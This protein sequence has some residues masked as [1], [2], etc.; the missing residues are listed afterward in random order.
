MTDQQMAA[1][2][3]GRR[4]FI[5]QLLM[6]LGVWSLVASLVSSVYANFRFFF[7][8]VLYEPPFRFRAGYPHEYDAGSISDRWHREHRVWMVRDGDTLYAMLA[9]CTHL[10]CLTGYFSSERLF[11]C[12]C[13]G[14]N[15]SVSGDPVSGP[16]P[17][18]LPRLAISLG[19]DGQLVIDKAV[20]EN[21]PGRRAEP[22]FVYH[23]KG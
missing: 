16:A 21:D 9:T 18:P 11:K 23:V 17:T 6:K 5:A 10:G 2:G 12:P 14:S 15:F 7:P 4:S 19:E 1:N 20:R 8:K 3:E 13:H 22:P